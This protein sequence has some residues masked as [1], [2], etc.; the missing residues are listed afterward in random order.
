MAPKDNAK[1]KAELDR[2]VRTQT[3]GNCDLAARRALRDM[4]LEPTQNNIELYWALKATCSRVSR[5]LMIDNA[6]RHKTSGF[7]SS[8]EQ[9]FW[10][11]PNNERSLE[12]L[13]RA[14][15][16]PE[17]IVNAELVVLPAGIAPADVILIDQCVDRSLLGTG[18]G[19]GFLG[20]KKQGCCPW[21]RIP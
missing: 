21:F 14:K 15:V 9:A 11:L 1:L 12:Q 5:K 8:L 19:A 6:N 16:G 4:S 3:A 17:H 13:A 20:K 10:A 2:A 7:S 18:I